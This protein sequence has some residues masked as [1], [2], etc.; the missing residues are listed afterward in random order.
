MI[1]AYF[2]RIPVV[3]IRKIIPK[4]ILDA[5]H[6]SI[7]AIPHENYFVAPET[8]FEVRQEFFKSWE[9]IS[10]MEKLGQRV[11]NFP[12]KKRPSQRLAETICQYA[13]DFYET[14]KPFI[15]LPETRFEV[16]CGPFSWSPDL[17]LAILHGRDFLNNTNITATAYGRHRIISNKKYDDLFQ[18]IDAL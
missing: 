5:I 11:F 18:K 4:R 9:S 13:P 3:S 17:R 10:G 6:P 16:L 7:P 2:R 1:D 14:K 12:D 8:L 15:P